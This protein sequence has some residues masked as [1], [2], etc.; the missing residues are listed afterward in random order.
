MQ[1]SLTVAVSIRMLTSMRT[2]VI[3]DDELFRRA[4]QRA[5]KRNVPLSA[6]INDALRA[7]LA[8]RRQE[9]P[10]FSMLTYGDAHRGMRLTPA[11]V[12]EALEDDDV[13]SL[14]RRRC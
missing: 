1:T 5:A 3:L 6:V 10:R 7:A 13:R 4:K 8:P 12:S 14:L 11:E 9:A 2:T